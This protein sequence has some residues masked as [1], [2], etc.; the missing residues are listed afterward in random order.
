M[1]LHT[2]RVLVV[3]VV[4]TVLIASRVRHGQLHI[5]RDTLTHSHSLSVRPCMAT[6]LL[7][8]P[9]ILLVVV[10]VLGIAVINIRRACSQFGLG[11]AL[12]PLANYALLSASPVK[13]LS[14]AIVRLAEETAGGPLTIAR[15]PVEIRGIC[16]S[17]KHAVVHHTRK[18][19]HGR[20][21]ALL[22]TVG[23]IRVALIA[24]RGGAVVA[25]QGN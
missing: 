3:P 16:T 20:G 17:P 22:G 4:A 25:M 5:T 14:V 2:Y 6:A 10:T 23:R 8:D 7:Y 13:R 21:F 24:D 1:A 19:T 18:T 15:L 9:V 11:F 12:L